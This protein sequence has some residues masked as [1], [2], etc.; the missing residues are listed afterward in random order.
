MG[1]KPFFDILHKE[2]IV[3]RNHILFSAILALFL[4]A[5]GGGG[6]SGGSAPPP[7]QTAPP[8][9]SAPPPS[10][11]SGVDLTSTRAKILAATQAA[12]SGSSSVVLPTTSGGKITLLPFE[13]YWGFTLTADNKIYGLSRPGETLLV[14][15]RQVK[16]ACLFAGRVGWGVDGGT[17]VACGPMLTGD[18]S[19]VPNYARLPR[20]ANNDRGTYA[21][22][23][24][25]ALKS[26]RD[27]SG[28]ADDYENGEVLWGDFSSERKF[29]FDSD[30]AAPMQAR[31]IESG[32]SAGLIEYGLIGV[33]YQQ[34]KVGV[35]AGGN[36]TLKFGS[37]SLGGFGKN[38]Q[39]TD[40]D[41]S[42]PLMYAWHSNDANGKGQPGWGYGSTAPT[43]KT[44]YQTVDANG[45]FQVVFEGVTCGS[46]NVTV[47]KP[48]TIN[49]QGV[50]TAW[51]TESDFY[52][53]GWLVIQK[54]SDPLQMWVPDAGVTFDRT[55]GGQQI[56]L[57]PC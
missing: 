24:K 28:G 29:T 11:G 16:W 19:P 7:T 3:I 54:E 8:V 39:L 5:C 23:M 38:N 12:V 55:E 42:K 47:Y 53:A 31:L 46:G 30:S 41:P 22:I 52:G 34:A 18:G 21:V 49:D 27:G 32:P 51:E 25:G 56:V 13:Q 14:D 57:R 10:T 33:G 48:R 9:I 37:N 2:F 43:T 36:L 40:L 35:G 6:G 15:P 50:V 44:A 17:S 4:A 26:G 45:N 1:N 20:T